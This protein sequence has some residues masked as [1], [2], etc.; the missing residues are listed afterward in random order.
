[1]ASRSSNDNAHKTLAQLNILGAPSSFRAYL[2]TT[3]TIV[4]LSLL[5]LFGAVA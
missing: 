1:M 3:R 5:T 2:R 4:A